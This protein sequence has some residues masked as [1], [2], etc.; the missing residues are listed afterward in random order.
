[1]SIAS[2]TGNDGLMWGVLLH[3]GYN[4]WS[5]RKT[6]ERPTAH[7]DARTYLRF[8]EALWNDLLEEAV[9]QGIN[10]VVLDLGEGVCYD[11]HPELAVEGSW[12]PDKL[13]AELQRM[14]DMGLEPLPKLNFSTCHDT[15]LGTYARQVSTGP[16]YAVCRDLIAEVIDIFDG[17]A[18][19][20]LGMDEETAQHQRYY[21]YVVIRQYDL[22]WHDL[23][24]YIDQVERGGVQPWVWSDYVWHHPDRFYSRMPK[25]V[26]QSN[27][28]Y[29]DDFGPE[30][31]RA[32]AY[33]G[34]EEHGY[35][36]VPTGS[37]WSTP[38]NMGL[39]VE[40]CRKVISPERLKGFLQTVWRPTLEPYR[41]LHVEALAQLGEARRRFVEQT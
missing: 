23:Y 4:M 3:L 27:W 29:D 31:A 1:M 9:R 33:V 2:S 41:Q 20:H 18:L 6:P 13:R 7:Y 14:R 11:S 24:F 39:T 21:E 37:N 10:T 17:P 36:Q 32:Q 8:D 34:L 26:L 30:A 35:D 25:T 12:P 19:F 38:H 28:Y 5:D 15:W 16:Y 40:F 22:W